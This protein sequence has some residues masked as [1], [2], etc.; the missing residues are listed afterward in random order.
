MPEVRL[1]WV[2]LRICGTCGHIGCCD[3]S[4]NK[5]A[6][7]HDPPEGR[8]RCYIDEVMLDLGDRVAPQNGPIPRYV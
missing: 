2:H 1:P 3:G 5:H 4:P 6:T 8:R 7:R